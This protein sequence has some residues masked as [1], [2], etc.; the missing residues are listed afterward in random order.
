MTDLWLK[1]SYSGQD[2]SNCVETT[3][4]AKSGYSSNDHSSDCVETAPATPTTD[5]A[6]RDSK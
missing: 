1:S 5:A 3:I 2:P 4:W 6:V